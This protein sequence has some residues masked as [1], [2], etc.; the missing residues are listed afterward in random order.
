MRNILRR[1]KWGRLRPD[2]HVARTSVRHVW[3]H[4]VKGDSWMADSVCTSGFV[5]AYRLS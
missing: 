3:S 2:L 4:S 5:A 1:C